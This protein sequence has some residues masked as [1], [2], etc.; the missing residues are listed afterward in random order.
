MMIHGDYCLPNILLNNWKFSGVIDL[1]AAGRGDRQFDLFK[2]AWSLNF[3]I[4]TDKYEERFFD[5][6]GSDM[7][8]SETLRTVAAIE[9]FV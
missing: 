4:K 8:N 5:A 7:V 1:G 9:V 3:N 6:Y 2:G